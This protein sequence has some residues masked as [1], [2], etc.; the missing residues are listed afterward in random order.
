MSCMEPFY[1]DLFFVCLFG[2]FLFG[3]WGGGI[4]KLLDDNN[5]SVSLYVVLLIL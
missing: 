1:V 5:W 3:E 4:S 2:G